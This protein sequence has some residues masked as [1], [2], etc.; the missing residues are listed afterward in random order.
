MRIFSVKFINGSIQALLLFLFTVNLAASFYMPIIAVFIT[1]NII[2]AT[3]ATVGISI[4]V[5]NI[6]KSFIQIPVAKR[7]DRKAGEE[8]D[9]LVIFIGALLGILYSFG[10]LVIH[11]TWQLYFLEVLSGIADACMMASYYAIFSHHIDK[12]SE[13]FEWSLFS[14]GVGASTGIG[15]II[16]GFIAENYGFTS[17]FVGAGILNIAGLFLLIGLYPS[18]KVLRKSHHYKTISHK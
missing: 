4:A 3:L 15:G 10:Y 2:G 1:T 17:L 5:Y 12:N 8:D 6:V 7:L 16:G 9:F 18:I 11:S 14:V 13:G